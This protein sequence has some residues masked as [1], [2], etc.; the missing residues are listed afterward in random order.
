MALELLAIDLG[1]RAFHIYGIDT[2]GVILSRKVSRA[3]L[4]HCLPAQFDT[5]CR[6][7]GGAVAA[8]VKKQVE[9]TLHRW[10]ASREVGRCSDV[11]QPL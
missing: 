2:D 6:L 9:R 3:K 4:P 5:Y 1:K 7:A 8:L 11:E 10:K